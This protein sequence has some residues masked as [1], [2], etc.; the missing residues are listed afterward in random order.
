MFRT[1]S[2]IRV[3]VDPTETNGLKKQPHIQC[4]KIQTIPKAKLGREIGVLTTADMAKVDLA[5]A[6]HLNLYALAGQ[7]GESP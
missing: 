4:E 7:T 5:L 3:A 2:E 6:F 1:N